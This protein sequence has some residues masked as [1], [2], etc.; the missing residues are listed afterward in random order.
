MIEAGDKLP[1]FT[2]LDQ[3]GKTVTDADWKGH[4]VVLFAF[5]RADTPG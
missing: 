3:D 5:P 1:K 2:L 4:K